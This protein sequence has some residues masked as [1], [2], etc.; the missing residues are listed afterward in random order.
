MFRAD[1]FCNVFDPQSNYTTAATL[2]TYL[3]TISLTCWQKR[4]EANIG[5]ETLH[6]KRG[7]QK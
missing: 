7:C 2:F 6:L 3:L 4:K 5:L 1:D